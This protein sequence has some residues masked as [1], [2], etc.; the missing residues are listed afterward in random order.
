MYISKIQISNFRGFKD[1]VIVEFH[2]GINIIIGANN[3]GKYN[4][5]KAL[6]LI[7]S[8]KNKRLTTDDFN[9]QITIQELRDRTPK[10]QISAFFKEGR[11]GF[12]SQ[13]L[14][15]LL[16]NVKYDYNKPRGLN[17]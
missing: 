9:K 6:S 10:V 5:I 17:Q 11:L 1:P 2:E 3:S 14:T 8:D 4:L 12:M 16:R 15:L 7:F 13:H